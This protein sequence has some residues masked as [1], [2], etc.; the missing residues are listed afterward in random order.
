MMSWTLAL[1]AQ[2]DAVADLQLRLHALGLAFEHA[3]DPP[4][5]YGPGTRAALT[6][7]QQ[8]YGLEVDGVCGEL[9]WSVLVEAGYQLGDRQLY[10]RHPMMRG[11]DIADLQGRLGALGFDAGK[12]DGIFGPL[13]AAALAEFQRNVGLTA[14]GIGGRESV[15]ALQRLGVARTG[16]LMVNLVREREQFRI[17]PPD[18][19][20]RRVVIGHGG[21]LGALVQAL[22]RY[23]RECAAVVLS[24][25]HPD[26]SV[27]ARMANDF[28]ADVYLGVRVSPVA[29]NRVSYF[30]GV[31]FWSEPGLTLAQT[32]AAKLSSVTD[33]PAQ[34]TGMRLPVL[35]ETRM[36]AVVAEIGP[37]A[38]IVAATEQC[39]ESF[40]LALVSWAQDP[41]RVLLPPPSPLAIDPGF[42]DQPSIQR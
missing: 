22:Q 33:S 6:L 25:H 24:V 41:Q 3:G 35:R 10:L 29:A 31:K 17:T 39:A 5:L 2:G 40:S 18:L 21:D 28:G 19:A 11:D 15:A 27:Q 7:F 9:T 38:A 13:T 4:G 12:A 37:A 23:L 8:R 36:P 26:G 32:V 1:G 20:G 14:D 16:A 42:S 34:V 30:Q